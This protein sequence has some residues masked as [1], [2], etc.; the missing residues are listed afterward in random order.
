MVN[1]A[2]DKNP[3]GATLNKDLWHTLPSTLRFAIS[4][5]ILALDASGV[6]SNFI[7]G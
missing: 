7:N 5:N 2:N 3:D 6:A 4:S 1:K